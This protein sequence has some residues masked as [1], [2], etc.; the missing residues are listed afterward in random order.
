MTRKGAIPRVLTILAIAACALQ[1]ATVEEQIRQLRAQIEAQERQLDSLRATLQQE[2]QILET[3]ERPALEKPATPAEVVATLPAQPPASPQNQ[4]EPKAETMIEPSVAPLAKSAPSS[5]SFSIG[6]ADF[7]PGGFMDFTFYRRSSNVASGIGTAFGDI[8]FRNTVAG[9][10]AESRLS[11]Q[12]SR[13][14]LRVDTR[15]LDWNVLGYVETDFLGAAPANVAVTSN[16]V[17]LR[18]R[19]YWVD[20]QKGKFEMLAGQSWSMMTPNRIGLSALPR[21]LSYSQDM[22]TNYQVGLTWARQPV[23]RLIAHPA[24]NWAWGVSFESPEQYI[25]GA[26]R[27]PAALSSTYAPQL[28]SGASTLAVPNVAPDIVSKLAYDRPAGNRLFHFELAGLYRTFRTYNPL[29]NRRF[30]R[31]A[32]GGA[33]NVALE[34]F[35][36]FHLLANQFI[37]D[38]GGRYLFGLGPDLVVRADGGMTLVHSAST[39]DGFEYQVTPRTLVYGYYGAAYFARTV[40]ID[41][42]GSQVGFGFTGSPAN[43]NRTIQEP[44]F[45]LV[46]TFWRHPSYGAL[47]LMVQGSYLSRNPWY[48]APATPRGAASRLLYVNLRYTLP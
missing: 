48:A 25:G 37:S 36:N 28:N 22:D 4:P 41:N 40:A 34:L 31:P 15:I 3:L 14:S 11:T 10:L 18:L 8:P 16:S 21:F 17:P 13:I 19:L 9:K 38:G 35:T 30:T 47:A 42:N 7:T 32:A 33:F 12:N 5:L 27:L 45:G 24:D 6:Q 29:T 1:A 43:S 44:S 26:V 20:V 2:K 23:F 39:L 46:Q